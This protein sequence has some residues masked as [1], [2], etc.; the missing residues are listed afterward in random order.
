MTKMATK[1]ADAPVA[2]GEVERTRAEV[3]R[4]NSL[5]LGMAGL[6]RQKAAEL[7]G[8]RAERGNVIL[9]AAD[10]AGA[11][12]ETGARVAAMLEE[13]E[14]L[15]DASRQARKRRLAAIPAVFIAQ[16]DEASSAAALLESEA[17]T[18]EAESRRLRQVLESFDGCAY[19]PTSPRGRDLSGPRVE[20]GGAPIIYVQV[21][22]FERLRMTA[23]GQ[24]A[25]AV[26]YRQKKPHRAGAL[27]AGNL[28]ELLVAVY[29]DAMRIGPSVDSIYAWSK[30]VLEKEQRRRRTASG[31]GLVPS[32][33]HLVWNHGTIE[34]QSFLVSS[35]AT[36]VESA[37]DSSEVERFEEPEEAS[38]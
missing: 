36:E 8:V 2:K 18:L 31:E 27:T 23:A 6:Y 22:K 30:Q 3:E 14:S 33:L 29:A 25:E 32:Q 37:F 7:A 5:E 13:M 17:A 11:A 4:L 1:T 28:E 19:S 38:A 10:P 9:D 16:A 21:P 12:R 26:Q 20:G 24:R 34:A 15:A 35:E